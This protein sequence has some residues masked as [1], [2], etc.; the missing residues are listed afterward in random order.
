VYKRLQYTRLQEIRSSFSLKT[1][2][3]KDP[4]TKKKNVVSTRHLPNQP[5]TDDWR[6]LLPQLARIV[7]RQQ[8]DSGLLVTAARAYH[9][10]Q[11]TVAQIEEHQLLIQASHLRLQDATLDA[12]L[13]LYQL[14]VDTDLALQIDSRFGF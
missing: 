5:T 4:V 6:V 2:P 13:T 14:S 12:Q 9:Q 7:D 10:H 11:E 8:L 3:E 1:D